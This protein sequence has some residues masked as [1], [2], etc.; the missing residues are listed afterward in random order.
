MWRIKGSVWAHA[1]EWF[2]ENWGPQAMAPLEDELLRVFECVPGS[3]RVCVCA[4]FRH[5]GEHFPSRYFF[6]SAVL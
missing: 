6:L 2:I 5:T 4:R 3:V 1:L